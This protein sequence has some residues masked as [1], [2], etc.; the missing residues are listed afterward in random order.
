MTLKI[1]KLK[2]KLSLVDSDSEKEKITKTINDL[3][4]SK[5]KEMNDK[6]DKLFLGI[7]K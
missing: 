2:K 6:Y 5:Y 7:S 4:E 1:N 3:K